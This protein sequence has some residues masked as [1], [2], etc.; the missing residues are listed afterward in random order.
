MYPSWTNQNIL[1]NVY[2]LSTLSQ[3][4]YSHSLVAEKHFRTTVTCLQH[5]VF[6]SYPET[7]PWMLGCLHQPAPV[8]LFSKTSLIPGEQ[9]FLLD[10]TRHSSL[11]TGPSVWPNKT[12]ISAHRSHDTC[13][14]KTASCSP[15]HCITTMI[16]YS[17]YVVS[18]ILR[19]LL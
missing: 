1:S 7:P 5:L 4:E 6:I 9:A 10:L 11:H 18:A 3:S 15:H 19:Q 12:L 17:S 8:G 16:F 2:I 14:C 13:C